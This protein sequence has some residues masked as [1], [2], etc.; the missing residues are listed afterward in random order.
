MYLL[1]LRTIVISRYTAVTWS[2]ITDDH[3]CLLIAQHCLALFVLCTK[4]EVYT[5]FLFR[6]KWM[7]GTDGQTDWVQQKM[8]PATE[9][10]S[11]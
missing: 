10:C 8:R 9:G 11:V 5:T 3:L 6:E 4:L 2:I 7:H 1:R